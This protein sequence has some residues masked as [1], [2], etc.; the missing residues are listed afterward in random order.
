MYGIAYSHYIEAR[1]SFVR[2]L[3]CLLANYSDFPRHHR[4]DGRGEF[5]CLISITSADRLEYQYGHSPL[6]GD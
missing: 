4:G 6:P 3:I 2:A 1:K 5:V